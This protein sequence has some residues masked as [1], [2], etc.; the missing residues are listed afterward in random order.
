MAGRP[1]LHE[2][3]AVAL[4]GCFV[5][6]PVRAADENDLRGFRVGMAVADL[7][8]A[9]YTGFTCAPPSATALGGWGDYRT[10]PR[11]A[12]TGLHEVRFRYDDTASE[13][14]MSNE[15]Y[16][17]T[18]VAGQPV[19]LS[20][21]IGEDGRLEGLRIRTDPAA[22]LFERRKAFLFSEQVKGRYGEEG[23]NCT[24]QPAGA[25]EEPVG[26]IFIKEHC[27]KTT[28]DRHYLLQRWLYRRAG[29][30]LR[31][32]SSGSVV[33]ILRHGT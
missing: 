25:E 15:R 13:L 22:K 20:L 10:C 9:G 23:W 3:A 21:L 7:P 11:D 6:A 28:A 31:Q 4:A 8:M 26:G 19:L 24:S 1:V 16:A 33:T 17:G 30:E 12:D 32:F 27:D 18:K 5:A 29:E 2:L 14:A